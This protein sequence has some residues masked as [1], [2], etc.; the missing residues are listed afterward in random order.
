MKRLMAGSVLG[1]WLAAAGCSSSPDMVLDSFEGPL[2][3]ETVDYGAGGGAVL[4]VSAAADQKF[5][6]EQ[7]L[8]L[9]YDISNGG[10]LWAARGYKL[11][12]AGADLASR[13]KLCLKARL[14][15][16]LPA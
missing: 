1:L 11:D 4:Q 15:E 13:R 7:S 10:Y 2:T 9:D 8:R 16:S 12:V 5:D 14:L 3:I 6:G